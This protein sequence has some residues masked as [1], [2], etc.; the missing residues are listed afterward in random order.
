MQGLRLPEVVHRDDAVQ[1]EAPEQVAEHPEELFN[2]V[3]D[4]ATLSVAWSRVV[5]NTRARSAGVDGRRAA[6]V[7]DAGVQ[8]FLE[9]DLRESVKAGTFRPMPIGERMIPK[10]GGD[11]RMRRLGIPTVT[12]RVV[13]AALKLVLE[14][15]FEDDFVPVSYGFRGACT[16]GARSGNAGR[17][18]G[19]R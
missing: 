9:D 18:S 16:P 2:L 8:A 10:P 3:H 6:D 13:Q 19:G 7:K 12:D 11:G 14:P 4:A 17:S 1:H 15:I 5:G